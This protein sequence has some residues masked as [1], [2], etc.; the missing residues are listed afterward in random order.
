MPDRQP[1]PAT[2]S[3]SAREKPGSGVSEAL[4]PLPEWNL[5]DLYA[6]LDDPAFAADLT[7]AEADCHAFADAYR[8]KLETIARG[9][10]G[11]EKLAEAVKRYESIEERLGR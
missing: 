2:A 4:G 5:A 1:R 9:R 7:R 3:A 8:G 6:G 11:V 10:G